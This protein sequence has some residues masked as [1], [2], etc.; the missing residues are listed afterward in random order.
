MEVVVWGDEVVACLGGVILGVGF[1]GFGTSL[2]GSDGDSA[3]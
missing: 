1:R 2:F 3:W